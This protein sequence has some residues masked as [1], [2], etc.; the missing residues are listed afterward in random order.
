[1]RF[2]FNVLSF[3]RLIRSH[4]NDNLQKSEKLNILPNKKYEVKILMSRR[5]EL[6]SL[7]GDLPSRSY[8]IKSK[9]VGEVTSKHYILEDLNL[10][11]DGSHSTSAYFLRPINKEGPFKT[12]IF[13]HS[14]GGNYDLGKNEL[15][16]GNVYLQHP[17]YADELTKMGYAV[18]CFDAW[19]FGS[20]NDQT[21][22]EL[23]KEALWK[24]QVL[25][26]K[27]IYDSLRAVD[28]L[29]SRPDVN[30]SYIGTL[31][32]SMGGYM[33]WWLAALEPRIKVCIDICSM[34]EFDALI[35]S[36][37]LE[38]HGIYFYVPSLLKYFS[39]S[40]INALI[41]PR[42]HLSLAG[43]ND[44]LTPGKGLDIVD[45]QMKKGYNKTGNLEAWKMV[46]SEQ[47]HVETQEMRE[48]VKMFLKKWL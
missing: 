45:E 8:P 28:Y 26:G 17:T 5:E 35:E 41:T 38:K 21:E 2:I 10:N 46:R 19:G 37:N 42:P 27:M 44:D 4:N 30:K 39:T 43:N 31:G 20:R 16:E 36:R 47:G 1:M 24:G 34:V 33:A 7:L 14:H 40:D 3:L 6:Y 18:L 32:M 23:F 25:W 13:N 11:F 12:V 48:E 9:K 22:G 15:I 29:S